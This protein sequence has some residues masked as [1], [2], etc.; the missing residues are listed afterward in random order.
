M[1]KIEKIGEL[2]ELEELQTTEEEPKK[3]RKKGR[4]KK[5]LITKKGEIDKRCNNGFGNRPKEEIK[6][7]AK[8]GYA[9]MKEAKTNRAA[10]SFKSIFASKLCRATR[11]KIVNDFIE[12]VQ[13]KEVRVSERIKLFEMLLKVMG[14]YQETKAT[15]EVNE[16]DN[17]I[18]LEI[19]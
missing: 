4:P 15:V 5:P 12:L 13:D 18:K 7:L 17:V 10:P 16:V 6:E 19:N 9:A 3:K 2:E 8:K 1:D 11:V 14:E